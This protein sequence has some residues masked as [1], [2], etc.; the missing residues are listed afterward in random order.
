[1]PLGDEDA[2]GGA[3]GGI[4]RRVVHCV[5]HFGGGGVAAR[6]DDVEDFLLAAA[7]S[8]CEFG[9]HC[10]S[11]TVERSRVVL[12]NQ[13][14]VEKP[15]IARSSTRRWEILGGYRRVRVLPQQ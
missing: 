11:S 1:M 10:R 7:E 9:W 6:V 4:G 12:K 2:Q 14:Y 15:T 5:A 8:G 3:D 13:Q